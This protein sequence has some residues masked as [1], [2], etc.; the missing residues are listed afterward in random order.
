D[1]HRGL[2][3]APTPQST[4]QGGL[5]ELAPRAARERR[6]P[7]FVTFLQNARSITASRLPWFPTY[8]SIPVKCR[9]GRSPLFPVA[10]ATQIQRGIDDSDQMRS[11]RGRRAR[12]ARPPR[13][14][15][16]RFR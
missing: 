6:R 11:L 10:P 8:P 16:G 7:A 12:L 5:R 4:D 9:L 15:V 14:L 13:R 1:G 3:T 2:C